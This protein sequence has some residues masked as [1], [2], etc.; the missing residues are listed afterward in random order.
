M[1]TCMSTGVTAIETSW[2]AVTVKIVFPLTDPKVAVMV[3]L[4]TETLVARPLDAM[5]ATPVMDDDQVTC[6]VRFCM[7]PSL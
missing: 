4:P 7:L 1:G 6:E 5:V 2:A 3:E